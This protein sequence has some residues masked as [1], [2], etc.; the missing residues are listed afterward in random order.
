[1]YASRLLRLV[2]Y[3]WALMGVLSFAASVYMYNSVSEISMPIPV[4]TILGASMIKLILPGLGVG[5]LGSI[6]KTLK[7]IQKSDVYV[8]SIE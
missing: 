4:A 8:E 2:G 3:G 1:M 6:L 7:E 5:G